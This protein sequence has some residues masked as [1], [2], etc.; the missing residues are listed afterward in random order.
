MK[1]SELLISHDLFE[2]ACVFPVKRLRVS[3]SVPARVEPFVWN[4]NEL[5]RCEAFC[6][7]TFQNVRAASV[8]FW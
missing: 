3:V 8:M 6:S 7:T 4:Y 2:E 5:T 1:C